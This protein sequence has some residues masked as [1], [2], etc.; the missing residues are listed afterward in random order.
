MTNREQPPGEDMVSSTGQPGVWRRSFDRLYANAT[1]V[2]NDPHETEVNFQRL[3]LIGERFRSKIG[4]VVFKG[5][6]NNDVRRHISSSGLQS[7]LEVALPIDEFGHLGDHLVYLANNQSSRQP[8]VPIEEM[9]RETEN[10][11]PGNLDPMQRIEAVRQKGYN[12]TTVISEADVESVLELWA[13]TFEWTHDGVVTLAARLK[14]EMELPA[15]AR[16][17]WYSAIKDQDKVI[18]LAMA[19]RLSLPTSHGRLDIV[20]ST[21]WRVHKADKYTRKGLMPAILAHL[22]AQILTDFYTSGQTVPLICAETNFQT[23]SDRA[24]FRAGF[25]IPARSGGSPSQILVQNVA[26]GDDQDWPADKLRDF[27]FMYLPLEQIE[28]NYNQAQAAAILSAATNEPL[29]RQ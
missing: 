3:V 26:V 2:S 13:P 21:E 12:F 24:G 28:A 4:R 11:L 25:R 17:V 20:E 23:R 10:Y 27:S 18:A 1:K 6:V 15:S 22:N 5:I 19:E 29:D 14:H 8:L 16:T 9:I 7:A